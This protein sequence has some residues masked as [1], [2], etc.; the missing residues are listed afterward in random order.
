MLKIL[1]VEDDSSKLRNVLNC[2]H[3]VVGSDEE[4]V[5][6]ARDANEAKR[7]IK[8]TKYDFL[9][10]DI[11][12]PERSDKL[13]SRDGGID[14]LEEILNRDV[15]LRPRE[16]I[17]LTAYTDIR[18]IASQRFNQDL[19]SV[20]QYDLASDDWF[21]K[22]QRKLRHLLAA[23]NGAEIESYQTE[24]A[25]VAALL[26]PE[27]KAVLRLPWT[28]TEYTVPNDGTIYHRGIFSRGTAQFSVVAAA[29]PRMGIANA[30]V[31]TS[32]LIQNFRPKYLAMTG[33]TAGIKG[34]CELGDIIAADPTWDWESGKRYVKDGTSLFSSAAHQIHLDSFVRGRLSLMSQR[35]D[36]LDQIRR[37]W[38][39]ASIRTALNLRLGPVASGSPV[40]ADPIITEQIVL[41]HRKLLGIDME[42]YGVFAAAEEWPT[43]E[44]RVF[45]IKSVCDFGDGD[46]DDTIQSYAA[47]TSARALQLFVEQLLASD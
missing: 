16:I 21:K 30:A 20:L 31:L 11:A 43:P 34:Q 19:W 10:L 39:G 47:Y 15:Y 6:I 18:E 44:P 24:L 37:E 9:I 22:V 1:V 17:G 4:R 46:K 5:H 28:W 13:P 23:E 35:I 14:L 3:S 41:Q 40:V 36:L 7:K 38:P 27:L 8:E 2:V 32:K 29:S 42:T 26:D 33:I 25:V 12:L 45:S